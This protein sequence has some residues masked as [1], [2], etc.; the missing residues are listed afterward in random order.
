MKLPTDLDGRAVDP[1]PD[2]V[3]GRAEDQDPHPR[4]RELHLLRSGQS[5]PRMNFRSVTRCSGH[6]RNSEV[7]L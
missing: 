3:Y 5:R 7:A 1:K 4:R 2:H 6:K